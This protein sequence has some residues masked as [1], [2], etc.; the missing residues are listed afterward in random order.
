MFVK[1]GGHRWNIFDICI[2]ADHA[3]PLKIKFSNNQRIYKW[4]KD[5]S[6]LYN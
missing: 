2:Y 1:Y 5:T 4:V 6:A 3:I